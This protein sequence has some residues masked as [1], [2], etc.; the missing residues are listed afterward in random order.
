[1]KNNTVLVDLLAYTEKKGGTDV[2]I[3]NLYK[4]MSGLDFDCN[5]LGFANHESRKLDMS[6]FPGEIFYS[7]I[8]S[9]NR[10]FWSIGE[11]ISLPLFA[12]RIKPVLIHCPA[13]F[14]PLYTS[15]PTLLT[16]HDSLYW[17]NSVLAPNGLLVPAV[18]FLQK[19]AIRNAKKIITSTK[20]SAKEISKI[21]GV[22][23]SDISVIYLAA[24]ENSCSDPVDISFSNYLLAG[25]NRFKHKNW[26]GLLKGLKLINPPMRPKIIITGGRSPDPLVEMVNSMGLEKDVVLLDWV[27]EAEMNSLYFNALAVI[28]PS[29]TESYLPLL[30]ALNFGKPLLISEI[31]PHKEIAGEKAF[32][33][34][35]N[36]P[37]S[38]ADAILSYLKVSKAM[39]GESKKE[40]S[41]KNNFSWKDTATQTLGLMKS[42]IN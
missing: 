15:C 13:N 32:Y 40:L 3:K 20:Y 38:I 22:D 16:V 36:S 6:W 8:K 5:F 41:A 28:V 30:Q 24:I 37:T 31:P 26:D 21:H 35:S 2:Y 14:G 17:S 25:G 34:D 11:I 39:L 4:N 18:R 27:P 1:L 10:F 23:L 12:R 7:N 33:F 9:E 29:H 42:I 19:H